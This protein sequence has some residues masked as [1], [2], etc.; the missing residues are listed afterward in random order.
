MKRAFGAKERLAVAIV[1]DVDVEEN[2]A[3]HIQPFSEEGKTVVENCQLISPAANRKKS[4]FVFAPREWQKGFLKEWNERINNVF[5][6]IAIPGSGKTLAALE[7]A[8]KWMAAGSDRRL[9]VVVPTDN[10]RE[11]W[12][13]EAAKFGISMQ[14]KEFG[15]NFK[16][17][18]Q[19][20]VVTY[21][22]VANNPLVF[23][24]LCSVAPTMVIFD[25]VHHC[26]DEAHFGIGVTTAFELAKEKLLMSGTPWKSDGQP[27]PFVKYDQ[28]GY[29]IGDY[30]YDYRQALVDDV[31]RYLVFDYA[32]GTITSDTTGESETLAEG[33][34]DTEAA[35]RLYK[36]LDGNGEYVREQIAAAHRK[37]IE[38]RKQIPDAGALAACIN[39]YHAVK[40]AAIIRD[41]TGCE[42]SVI[43]SDGD[44]ENDTVKEFRKS[45]KEW[46]VAV[47]KVSEGTDIKRL[48][49]LCYLTNTTS[50]LFFRQLIG[51]VSRV[52]GLDDFEGYVYLPAD[53]RLIRC[54]QNIENTQVQALREICEI[55]ARE[56]KERQQSLEFDSYSTKHEGTE[57]VLVGSER[58]SVADAKRIEQIA[59]S[60][61]VS[62][63][64]VLQII[65]MSAGAFAAS[66]TQPQA[67]PTLLE[68]RLDELRKKCNKTAFRLSKLLDIEVKEIHK[69]FK[70]QKEMTEADLEHKLKSLVDQCNRVSK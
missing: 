32:K 56:Q 23:R 14:T 4:D 70:P 35:S 18:F 53:P 8:R 9:I 16:H 60:T 59:E 25:E 58:I 66:H 37:L 52:R 62:M 7:A 1:G 19:G 27:I 43:V 15:T 6:L 51:R 10:L 57:L 45:K 31:V 50:E 69:R 64:K 61:G 54:A 41:V 48:Q 55:E 46:L 65:A 38:C 49:V 42:P 12:K 24:K 17:G 22:L 5:M 47:R 29:A 44:L 30:S 68:D 20:G 39:Q 21:S 34:N 63:Q 28:S 13:E 36:L 3:D 33:I 67:E 40:I 26:G 11:Q 2:A